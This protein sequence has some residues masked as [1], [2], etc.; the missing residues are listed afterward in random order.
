MGQ[1]KAFTNLNIVSDRQGRH[2]LHGVVKMSDG[3]NV[4][5]QDVVNK[6][7]GAQKS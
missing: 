4:G 2:E 3:L 1:A 6:R 7:K 5:L